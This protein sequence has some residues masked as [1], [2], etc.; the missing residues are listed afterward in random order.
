MTSITGWNRLEP[1]ARDPNFKEGLAQPVFDPAFFI[2]RAWQVGEFRGEDTGSAVL[3]NISLKTQKVNRYRVGDGTS[4]VGGSA[5]PDA[6]VLEE[7]VEAEG[8]GEFGSVGWFDRAEAA[9]G[10]LRL[11]DKQATLPENRAFWRTTAPFVDLPNEQLAEL[12]AEEQ[13]DYEELQTTAPDG[14]ALFAVLTEIQDGTRPTP[15]AYAAGGEAFDEIVQTWLA[16]WRETFSA[17]SDVPSAWQAHRMEH[18]VSLEVAANSADEMAT[19]EAREYH[20]GKLDWYNFDIAY[21]NT[22]GSDFENVET[23]DVSRVPSQAE[24]AGMPAPRWWE[25]EDAKIAFAQIEVA[26]DDLIKTVLV[27]FALVYGGDWLVVPVELPAGAI[28]KIEQMTVVDCFGEEVNIDAIE[29]STNPGQAWQMHHM[30]DINTSI[31]AEVPQDNQVMFIPTVA[32]DI[33]T[34][35]PRERVIFGRDEVAN[36]AFSAEAITQSASGVA[37]DRQRAY[38]QKVR[39]NLASSLGSPKSPNLMYHL[40]SEVPD[41]WIPFVP[42]AKNNE[43]EI[44]LRRGAFLDTHSGEPVRAKG[45]VLT[46]EEKLVI[47]EE[48]ISRVGMTVS[49]ATRIARSS[50]GKT[51]LWHGRRRKPGRGDFNSGLR[52]DAVRE[53]LP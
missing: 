40:S 33:A 47:A 1:V 51:I 22:L 27:D 8:V 45:R 20:G 35:E 4:H 21:G 41:F 49:R 16:Q 37:V 29:T 38:R 30:A 19:L 50:D 31:G 25:F 39:A 12:T 3:T 18:Q 7:L 11:L 17:R 44:D 36:L 28:H 10:F 32:S 9:L 5:V 53:D 26:P 42:V 13:E 34:G 24:F 23:S 14:L 46:P 43:R 48:E 6:Y 15:T 2:G 52:F